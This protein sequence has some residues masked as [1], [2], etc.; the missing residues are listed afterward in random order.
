M[1]SQTSAPQ[2]QTSCVTKWRI[3]VLVFQS[4]YHK[5]LARNKCI[6][7][8]LLIWNQI[9]FSLSYPIKATQNNLFLLP[10]RWSFENAKISLKNK[11]FSST[12]SWKREN[13]KTQICQASLSIMMK[14]NET[15][16]SVKTPI[17]PLEQH[18]IFRNSRGS[19][20]TRP[21]KIALLYL[22]LK[23]KV[24]GWWVFVVQP[25][26]TPHLLRLPIRYT[27]ARLGTL[28]ICPPTLTASIS[29][30]LLFPFFHS[31]SLWCPEGRCCLKDTQAFWGLYLL[32][33]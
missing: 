3:E 5:I 29:I 13:S 17:V 26:K 14:Y 10:N 27:S 2:I 32:C 18:F 9:Q 4:N 31:V 30:I 12:P 8:F 11:Y 23:E 24:G 7:F 6:N 25:F 19:S 28:P 33:L 1:N 21:R 16:T 22:P 15:S 20:S